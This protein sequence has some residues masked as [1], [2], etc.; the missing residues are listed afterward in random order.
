MSRKLI[1]YEL[2]GQ[3]RSR[4]LRYQGVAVKGTGAVAN[5]GFETVKS[6]FE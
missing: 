3:K 5:A 6:G 1:C 4:K 2:G